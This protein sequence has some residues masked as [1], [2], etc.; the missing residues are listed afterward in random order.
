MALTDEQRAELEALGAD[1]VRIKLIHGGTD[2]GAAVPGF[3]TGI[4]GGNLPGAM[5][6]IGWRKS[7]PKQKG[8]KLARSSGRG[9]RVGQVSSVSSWRLLSLSGRLSTHENRDENRDENTDC[10]LARFMRCVL[11]CYGN[12]AIAQSE[13]S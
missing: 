2:R 9:S 13:F 3:R 1:T 5:S 11:K 7:T 6:R 4:L 8:A 12:W 10:N